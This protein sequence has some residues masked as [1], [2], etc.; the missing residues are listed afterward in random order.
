MNNSTKSASELH[1]NVPP[2]WYFASIRRNPFQEFWHRKRFE[3][4]S[5][6][7]VPTNGR[8]LDIGCADGVFSNV[9]FK[10][11]KAKELIG[12]DV[13]RSSIVWANKHWKNKKIK[14]KVGNAHDLK[15]EANSFDAVFALEVME[16]VSD[17]DVVIKQVKRVLKKGGY[18]VM[19]VPTDN[20]L[21]KLIWYLWTKFGPG[22]IW[23]Q[24][25]I[26]S[27]SKQNTLADALIR[28]GFTIEIDDKFLLGMLNVV[29]ARK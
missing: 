13:L 24:T 11:T 3:K 4:I 9:I 29:R 8:V 25:H 7:I 18:T 20:L 27:F 26:Q 23:D 14:F 1:K 19:L 17:P 22:K 21:F 6:I 15:F 2:N 16:H 5:S 10:K 12:I 28:N